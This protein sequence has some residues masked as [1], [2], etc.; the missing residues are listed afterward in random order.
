MVDDKDWV[1]AES[2]GDLQWHFMVTGGSVDEET[3]FVHTPEGGWLAVDIAHAWSI[4][5]LTAGELEK[6]ARAGAD[7]SSFRGGWIR[8]VVLMS[9]VVESIRADPSAEHVQILRGTRFGISSFDTIRVDFNYDFRKAPAL[10]FS[11]PSVGWLRSGMML[12]GIPHL[13]DQTGFIRDRVLPRKGVL[14]SVALVDAQGRP[15]PSVSR[16]RPAPCPRCWD[17]ELAVRQVKCPLGCTYGD[18]G[19]LSGPR[20]FHFGPNPPHSSATVGPRVARM[21]YGGDQKPLTGFVPE[22]PEYAELR[23]WL[24]SKS[25]GRKGGKPPIETGT[26]EALITRT[27]LAHTP[28]WGKGVPGPHSDSELLEITR[29]GSPATPASSKVSLAAVGRVRRQMGY[30]WK[31]GRLVRS[32]APVLSETPLTD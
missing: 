4:S 3:A 25:G 30:R 17:D 31:K 26:I 28:K 27:A 6:R 9:W 22:N 23:R 1:L 16:S 8:L 12:G 18:T 5:Y 10:D 29:S 7:I 2:S 20:D 11:D 24:Q 13:A 14:A 32:R 21:M 19:S 15:V